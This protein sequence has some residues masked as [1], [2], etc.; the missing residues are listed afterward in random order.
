[1]L[2]QNIGFSKSLRIRKIGVLGFPN[3]LRF[4]GQF[5]E[6]KPNAVNR[7]ELLTN[8]GIPT[9]IPSS[10]RVKVKGT[11]MFSTLHFLCFKS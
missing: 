5:C 10:G 8:I 11:D 6:T 3:H 9:A 1:M 2:L 4:Q 7:G